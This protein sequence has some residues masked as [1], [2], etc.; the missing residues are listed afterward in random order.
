MKGRDQVQVTADA[1]DVQADPG[2]AALH[3]P[4]R[5]LQQ[6]VARLFIDGDPDRNVALP[7]VEHHLGDPVGQKRIVELA[8]EGMDPERRDLAALVI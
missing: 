1:G 7:I 5:G 6:D 4:G 2:D 3:R 8:G